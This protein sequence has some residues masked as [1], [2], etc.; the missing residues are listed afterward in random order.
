M[1]GCP[2]AGA[3]D[4]D[5]LPKGLTHVTTAYKRA[6]WIVVRLN[7]GYGLIEMVAASSRDRKHARIRDK[8]GMPGAQKIVG[9]QSVDGANA[10]RATV[11]IPDNLRV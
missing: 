8:A 9:N 5:E 6:L 3:G 7:V 1:P 2:Q 4:E 11:P 10:G